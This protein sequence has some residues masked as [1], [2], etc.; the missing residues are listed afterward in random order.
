MQA[1]NREGVAKLIGLRRARPDVSA[2][3]I[4]VCYLLL[5]PPRH[6][7]SASTRAAQWPAA[8]P[9]M[10]GLAAAGAN[11]LPKGSVPAQP[12]AHDRTN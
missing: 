2:F 5:P 1:L 7:T 10:T 8:S 9:D 6:H 4:G 11:P 3:V 12:M